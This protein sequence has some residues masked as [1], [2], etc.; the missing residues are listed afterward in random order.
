MWK[1]QVNILL[2]ASELIDYVNGNNPQPVRSNN[3]SKANFD[4]KLVAW[5]KQDSK[6]QRIIATSIGPTALRHIV[7]CEN[8]QD[9]WLKL[10]MVYEQASQAN[11]HML[12]QRFYSFE[13]D[14]DDDIATHISKLQNI[15]RQLKDLG[16]QISESMVITKVLMTLPKTFQHFCS[17]WESAAPE[18]QTLGNLMSRL[19]MEEARISQSNKMQENTTALVAKRRVWKNQEKSKSGKCYSC[20]EFGHWKRN[21][22]SRRQV[23]DSKKTNYSKK[24]QQGGDALTCNALAVNKENTKNNWYLDSGASDHM[25]FRREWLKGYSELEVPMNVRIGSGALI[26][27]LGV[28]NVDIL[29]YNGKEW[30]QKQ[31]KN[32]LFVPNITMNLL[33]QSCVLDKGFDLLSDS[34]QCKFVRKGNHE[35]I[36][37]V[38]ERQSQLFQMRFKVQSPAQFS[39]NLAMKDVLTLK[40][41]RERLAHQNI[42]QVRNILV[43]K[44]IKFVDNNFFV[45]DA[46][47]YGKQHRRPFGKTE[48]QATL[49]GE[50]V[51][52]DVCGPMEDKSIGGSRYFVLFKDHFSHFRAVYFIKEKTDVCSAIE[53]FLYRAKAESRQE[54]KVLRTD[55]GLEFVNQAVRSLL[56]KFSIRHETTV[57][58]TPQQNGSA[59]RENRTIVEAARTMLYS[60]DL[61][62]KFW[63]EAVNT[64][65]YVLN[66]TGTSPEKGKTPYELWCGKPPCIGHF[67]VFGTEVFVHVPKPRRKKWD[68]KAERGIFVGYEDNTKGFRV[69]I[70]SSQKVDVSRDVD[71]RELNVQQQKTEYKKSTDSDNLPVLS[72]ESTD[73]D[74]DTDCPFVNEAQYEDSDQNQDYSQPV[75]KT[76]D[77]NN[78]GN[79]FDLVDIPLKERLRN[80]KARTVSNMYTLLEGHAFI[81][82]GEPRNYKEAINSED[83]IKWKSAMEDE[84]KS[85]Y[86]NRTWDLVNLPKGRKVIDN[87]WVYKLKGQG[88][89]TRYKARLVVRGFT[90]EYGIDYLETFSPVVKHTSIRSILAISACE[91]LNLTQ[92]DVKT[93]FLNGDLSEEIYMQQPQGF[94]NGTDKVCKLRKSLYGLKQASRCWNQKFTEVLKGFNLSQSTMGPCV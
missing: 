68:K 61:Q 81:S 35:S 73:R 3:E 76:I 24:R 82:Q 69:W 39:A 4:S 87:K 71:F 90:Q 9:M 27:A 20:N 6:A 13:K 19:V 55:N 80:T 51:H 10:K 38:G 41:W 40:D 66:R 72:A 29:A 70:P 36:V 47:N 34:K 42:S 57:P 21:C 2:N 26:P 23:V 37:A 49:P 93:A 74:G 60:K 75:D 25:T 43:Q 30:I 89:K 64:A 18:Q 91:N 28:G 11:I 7:N 16:E 62:K 92:F 83:A 94:E 22:P 50:L 54:V 5:K 53:K 12:H 85:L 58:Y 67:K 31:L 88:E 33:S 32:V 86:S 48:F 78:E 17:A 14:P 15:V 65:V 79:G 8:A 46:C 77:A 63:A 1:F 84:I 59:E 45:C 44:N 56:N 52:A